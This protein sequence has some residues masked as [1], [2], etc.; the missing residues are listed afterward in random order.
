MVK[1]C[2]SMIASV[3]PSRREASSFERAAPSGGEGTRLRAPWLRL[4]TKD[5]KRYLPKGDAR[6]EPES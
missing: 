4:P 5:V 3:Q 2:A 6:V 1:P